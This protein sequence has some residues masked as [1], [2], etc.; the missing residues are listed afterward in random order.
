MEHGN[1][2]L[3]CGRCGANHAEPRQGS[4]PRACRDCGASLSSLPPFETTLNVASAG[5][6]AALTQQVMQ[7]RTRTPT[8]PNASV[9]SPPSKSAPG[10][11]SARPDF[12]AQ[13]ALLSKRSNS[14]PPR[15]RRSPPPRPEKRRSVVPAIAIL[16]LLGVAAAIAVELGMGHHVWLPKGS[17][18]RAAKV[19]VPKT[20]PLLAIDRAQVAPNEALAEPPASAAVQLALPAVEPKAPATT[21]ARPERTETEPATEPE[22]EHET[23]EEAPLPAPAAGPFDA[24]A[25][26]RAIDQAAALAQRCK[27]A[28]DPEGVAVVV[29]TFAPSGRTTTATVSG[30]PFAGTPIGSCIAARFRA[31]SV[32]PYSGEFITVKKSFSIKNALPAKK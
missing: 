21:K 8:A 32:P 26:E 28:D 4:A 10:A 13:L 6:L 12:D 23:P 25:A 18:P 17:E 15:A 31:A 7:E 16:A 5:G 14:E 22:S 29:V 2:H 3:V 1:A 19:S 20:S 11:T 9:V 30:E 27:R 24:E